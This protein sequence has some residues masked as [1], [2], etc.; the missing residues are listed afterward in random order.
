MRFSIAVNRR[1]RSADGNSWEDEANFFDCVFFGRSAESINQ[2]LEKGRSVS[3]TGE[4]RQSRWESEGQSRSRVEI[5]CSQVNLLGSG[6]SDASEHPDNGGWKPSFSN[7]DHIGQSA[8]M[9]GREGAPQ[10][11]QPRFSGNFSRTPQSEDFHEDYSIG[12]PESY[13]DDEVPF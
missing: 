1:K 13:G 9:P 4:L 11:S 3:V 5:V 12:G 6:R 7:S 2:Y 10:V 8:G